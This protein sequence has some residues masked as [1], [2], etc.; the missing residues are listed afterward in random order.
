MMA[1]K[2]KVV[3]E[4]TKGVEYPFKKNKVEPVVGGR[5]AS[6]RLKKWK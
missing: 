5:P 3:G 4:L 6:L 2:D 1:Q